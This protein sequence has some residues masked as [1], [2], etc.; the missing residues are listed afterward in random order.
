MTI[1]SLLG[2]LNVILEAKG[3]KP[4]KS[5]KESKENLQKRIQKEKISTK[6]TKK[7]AKKSTSK[8]SDGQ[9]VVDIARKLGINPKVARAKLRRAGLSSNNGRWKSMK[10]GSKEHTQ[11]KT[12]LQ[13]NKDGKTENGKNTS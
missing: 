5:W 7:P 10:V 1:A 9:S 8:K 3:K 13:G 6:E 2:Q 4:L 11:I 12:I